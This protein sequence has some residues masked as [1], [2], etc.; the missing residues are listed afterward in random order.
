VINGILDCWDSSSDTLGIGDFLIGVER[1]IEI[2][3]GVQD[4]DEKMTLGL[5]KHIG[6]NLLG[7]RRA[8]L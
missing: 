3:L 7:S 1:N 8:C 5:M 4:S 6:C 2:D